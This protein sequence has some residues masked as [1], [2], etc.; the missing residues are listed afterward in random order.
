MGQDVDSDDRFYVSTE[1]V[2]C[3]ALTTSSW[4]C[5]WCHHQDDN[6]DD[7]SSSSSSA[8]SLPAL[9]P[10]CFDCH[11]HLPFSLTY[12][13]QVLARINMELQQLRCV[14]LVSCC[15]GLQGGI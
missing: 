1:D 2:T 5:A 13:Y 11:S 7:T 8:S 3:E 14:L 6:C 12:N 9:L 15:F 4:H 10:T